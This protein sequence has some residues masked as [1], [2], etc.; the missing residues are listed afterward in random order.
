MCHDAQGGIKAKREPFVVG[1]FLKSRF[2][3]RRGVVVN[4]LSDVGIEN[5]Y[6]CNVPFVCLYIRFFQYLF[7]GKIKSFILN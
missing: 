5:T 7:G 4:I 3:G 1:V 6:I 2:R